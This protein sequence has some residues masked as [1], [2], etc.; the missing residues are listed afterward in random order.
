[1]QVT[2]LTFEVKNLKSLFVDINFRY[3]VVV[4][5]LVMPIFG[6]KTNGSLANTAVKRYPRP[7]RSDNSANITP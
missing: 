6:R 3:Y 2:N 1:M 7:Y 4:A 5:Y